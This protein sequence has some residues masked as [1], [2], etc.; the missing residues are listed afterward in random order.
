MFVYSELLRFSSSIIII[1]FSEMYDVLYC[2][3]D[4]VLVLKRMMVINVVL[5]LF[6][7][8]L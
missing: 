1:L 8:V 7:L 2:G 6:I 3:R 4:L 5:L